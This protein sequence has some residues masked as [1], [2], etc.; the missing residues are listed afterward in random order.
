ML[1][2][3]DG[4][5]KGWIVAMADGWP[6]NE[7]PRLFFCP[8][9]ESVLKSTQTCCIVVID[10]P[11]GI[12][13]KAT[14]RACD[15]EAQEILRKAAGRVFLTPPEECLTARTPKDFQE[16]HC[17]LRGKGAGVPVWG[18]VPKIKEVNKAMTSELQKQ[19]F[20]FHPELAWKHLAEGHILE[21]KHT[22][23]G[24]LQRIGLL[25]KYVGDI[26]T[27][28]E[29][30]AAR[31]SKI[32]DVLDS[33]VGLYTAQYIADYI[34]KNPDWRR[35]SCNR[36]LPSDKPSSNELGMVIWF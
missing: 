5:Q 6:C 13:S 27:F 8:N 33:L 32:D 17:N 3:V 30:E 36:R 2:G 31:K 34:A 35:C 15:L 29:E 25:E 26:K 11:I 7:Q 14:E 9:F 28:A 1:A 18:I 19:V 20:E 4:C 12:P 23:A 10:I 24:I 21:S 16:T 22:T